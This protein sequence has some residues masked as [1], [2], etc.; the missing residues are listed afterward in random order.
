MRLKIFYK[1]RNLHVISQR[2][3]SLVVAILGC[4]ILMAL[5][6]LAVTTSTQ[7]IR[8]SALVVGEKKVM[9]ATETGVHQVMANF[10][11]QTHTAATWPT[12]ISSWSSS[13]VSDPTSQ[14][15]IPACPT[16]QTAAGASAFQVAGYDIGG[17]IKWVQKPYQATVEGRNTRYNSTAQVQVGMGVLSPE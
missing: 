11:P 9:A 5:G 17:E 4:M 6:F 1:L 10:N 8:A 15:R 7:D 3:F 13:S 16:V 12:S 2:G 14:Y